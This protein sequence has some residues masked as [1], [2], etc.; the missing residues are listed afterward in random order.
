M[1]RG[2]PA[3]HNLCYSTGLGGGGGGAAVFDPDW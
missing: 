1:H 3:M 2:P